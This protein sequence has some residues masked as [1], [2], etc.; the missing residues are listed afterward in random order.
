MFMILGAAFSEQEKGV[1]EKLAIS[2]LFQLL[3][4]WDHSLSSTQFQ[5]SKL[6]FASH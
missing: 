4:L 1:I 6:Y 2:M 3:H 5:L